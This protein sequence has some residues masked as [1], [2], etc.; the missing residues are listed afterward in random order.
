MKKYISLILLISLSLGITSCDEDFLTVSPTS[1]QEAGGPATEGAIL[2]NLAASYQIL[3]L[4]S[5]A[6]FNFNSIVLMSDLRSDDIYKG[7][8]DAGDQASLYRLSQ[9]DAS[10][11]E[12]PEGLWTIFYSGLSRC[13]N[14]I[15]ACENAVEV[16]AVRLNQYKAEARFLRAYYVHWLWKFWGN[17]PYFEEDLEAPYM[18]RQFTADEVYAEIIEDLDFALAEDK[19]PMRTSSQD[20]GRVSRAAVMMLKA[21]VVMY[22]KDEAKYAEVLNDM[23]AIVASNAYSLIDYASIWDR[24]GEFSDESIFEVN[25]LPDGKSWGG[26]WSGFGTVLPRFISPNELSGSD[27]LSGEDFYEGGWGFGP[28]RSEAAAIFE[29]GDVR[30]AGSINQFEAGAYTPRFQDTGYFMAKYAARE[31]YNEAPFDADLNFENNLRI[32]RY[33]EVLLNAAEL[34][35]INGLAPVGGLSAQGLL[36]QIRTRAGLGSI[37][38]TASNIKLERRREFLGEGMRFWDLVRWGDAS[39]LTESNPEFSS[40]RTWEDY[41]K[42]LPIPQSDIDKTEGEFKLIQNPG[43]N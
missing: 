16:D 36:D 30:L 10:A 38:A 20:D 22:Q 3:L 12:L 24:E 35:T 4:D 8:G 2:S 9:L 26:A 5:Y 29:N 1:S 14:A 37:S 15:I 39:I 34:M 7:G 19:L 31:D 25:H 33:S 32:F 27:L 40:N 43:Y 17:I 13:N 28:V 23:N 21:R 18:S 41:K 42:Y 11:N 6:N